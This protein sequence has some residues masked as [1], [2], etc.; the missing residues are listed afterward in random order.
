LPLLWLP[1]TCAFP[2]PPVL[3]PSLACAVVPP[4]FWPLWNTLTLPFA[5]VV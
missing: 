5:L 3:Q 4:E 1:Y 2:L